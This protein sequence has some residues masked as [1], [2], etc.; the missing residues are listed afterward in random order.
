ML[1]VIIGSP[2]SHRQGTHWSQLEICSMTKYSRI[3]L[4]PHL[5]TLQYYVDPHLVA[6]LPH[7]KINPSYTRNKSSV[8]FLK[9]DYHNPRQ[10]NPKTPT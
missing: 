1:N 3:A 6:A 2:S 5:K 10:R 7:D 9:S 8:Q 4:A